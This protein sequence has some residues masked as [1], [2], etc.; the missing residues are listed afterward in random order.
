[1]SFTQRLKAEMTSSKDGAVKILTP[2]IME[3]YGAEA[4]ASG[5]SKDTAELITGLMTSE[6]NSTRHSRFGA[7]SRGEC[8]RRQM[9]AFLGHEQKIPPDLSAIFGDGHWRHLRWQAIGY[10][11]GWF[12]EVEVVRKRPEYNLTVSFDGVNWTERFGF[13]LKGTSNLKKIRDEGPPYKHLLQMATML[14]AEEE[15]DRFVYVAEDKRSQQFEEFVLERRD[16]PLQAAETELV[17]LSQYVANEE[18]PAILPECERRTGTT[19]R[20]CPFKSI[21]HDIDEGAV[22]VRV[23]EKS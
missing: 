10:E 15:L 16:L 13:E 7:S 18:L 1:M 22:D 11:E 9:F 21:C 23:K 19:F 2:R 6:A 12:E 20:G 5:F 17:Y 4:G 8:Y 14:L 3:R